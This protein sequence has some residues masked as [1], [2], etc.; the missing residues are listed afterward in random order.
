MIGGKF[1]Q[2]DFFSNLYYIIYIYI[3]A[4]ICHLPDQHIVGLQDIVIFDIP[5]C[6]NITTPTLFTG[7]SF[8]FDT[9]SHE[10]I[11]FSFFLLTDG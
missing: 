7:Y 3:I 1:N 4:A 10:Q 5:I 6:K 9:I 2:G 8:N 11:F